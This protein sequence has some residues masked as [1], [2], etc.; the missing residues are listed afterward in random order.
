MSDNDADD[1]A[2][3]GPLHPE[4]DDPTQLEMPDWV[5]DTVKAVADDLYLWA[6]TSPDEHPPDFAV[7]V[8]R[9]ATDPRMKEVWDEL[10]DRKR[11]PQLRRSFLHPAN[12]RFIET[13]ETVDSLRALTASLP[14]PDRPQHQAMAI[15]FYAAASF[16]VWTR[17]G[18]RTR[19]RAE[20]EEDIGEQE[21]MAN[22]ARML[23]EHARRTDQSDVLP[24]LECAAV[25]LEKRAAVARDIANRNPLI[26]NRHSERV[27]S[28]E[29]RGFIITLVERSRELF[30]TPLFGLVA[31]LG[32]VALGR[33]DLTKSTVRAMVRPRG[34]KDRP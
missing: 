6:K 13:Y 12:E 11:E 30:G 23:A 33:T 4:T 8:R 25:T 18:G 28:P 24:G 15:L 22:A 5:P 19:T 21:K 9:L 27:G 1:S 31:I 34:T 3:N 32:N 29:E 7:R 10:S 26:I 14:E 17:A 2:A 20:A 16:V